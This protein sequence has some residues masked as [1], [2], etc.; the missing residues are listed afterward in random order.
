MQFSRRTLG[1]KATRGL[2]LIGKPTRR[3]DF[4][5]EGHRQATFGMDVRLPGMKVAVVARP[6]GLRGQVKP[7]DPAKA[8]AIAGVDAVV[9]IPVDRGGTGVCSH[10]YRIL[11]GAARAARRSR[12]N[13]ISARRRSASSSRSTNQLAQQ[14]AW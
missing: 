14:P 8:R 12:S 13:G 7:F 5:R 2:E 10:R 1:V 6:P 3:I 9:P 4:A 11:A